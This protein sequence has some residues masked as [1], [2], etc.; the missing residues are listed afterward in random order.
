ML[1]SLQDRQQPIL[2]SLPLASSPAVPS[3]KKGEALDA[4]AYPFPHLSQHQALR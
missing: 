4:F 1:G 3:A 2:I